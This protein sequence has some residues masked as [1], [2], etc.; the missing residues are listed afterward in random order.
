[1]Q[2]RVILVHG[3]RVKAVEV[4]GELQ[5][6]F[7]LKPLLEESGI[8]VIACTYAENGFFDSFSDSKLDENA[9][10][11]LTLSQPGDHVIFHSN[12]ARVVHRALE[13]GARYNQLYAV[14]PAIGARREW[15]KGA[16]T[17]LNIIFNSRDRLCQS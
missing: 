6:I 9:H 13:L 2:P 5:S 10:R 4:N 17:K 15:P 8:E 1:M 12:G 14:A 11:L 3:I 16:F 7:R